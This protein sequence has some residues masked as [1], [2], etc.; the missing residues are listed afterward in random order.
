[1][2]YNATVQGRKSS[3]KK[4]DRSHTLYTAA[5]TTT[6]LTTIMKQVET[7]HDNEAAQTFLYSGIQLSSDLS[8][9][10]NIFL[11]L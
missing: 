6:H 2:H 10:T 8:H 7:Q 4:A 5:V 1:M 9:T 11:Q 3:G